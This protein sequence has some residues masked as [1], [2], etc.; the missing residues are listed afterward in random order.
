MNGRRVLFILLAILALSCETERRMP[1]DHIAVDG[2]RWIV[3]PLSGG[4]YVSL[5]RIYDMK[6]G[7]SLSVA[8]L[9][10]RRLDLWTYRMTA[11][12]GVR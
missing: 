5:Q 9:G 1:D 4:P 3:M 10:I 12:G 7:D 11:H 8:G 6:P 2:D